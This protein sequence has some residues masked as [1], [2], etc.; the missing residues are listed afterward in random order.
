[1]ARIPIEEMKDA[2]SSDS[3]TSILTDSES[4][5]GESLVLDDSIEEVIDAMNDF[6]S[7]IKD[8]NH[9]E[10]LRRE[11]TPCIRCVKKM[12]DNVLVWSGVRSFKP[13]PFIHKDSPAWFDK[14][15]AV[16]LFLNNQKNID[17]APELVNP[18][19]PRRFFDRFVE[20]GLRMAALHTERYM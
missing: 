18:P 1:M 11:Y 7:K 9:K 16:T 12:F 15:C 14:M 2:S 4:D 8:P 5:S 6:V 10:W 20:L 17:T 3:E 13:D 19:I